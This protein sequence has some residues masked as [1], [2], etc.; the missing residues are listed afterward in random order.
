MLPVPC[1][2]DGR[3]HC[4]EKYR[5]ACVTQGEG[6]FCAN[7]RRY[8]LRPGSVLILAAGLRHRLHSTT[9]SPLRL[10]IIELLPGRAVAPGHEAL[11][12]DVFT[13]PPVVRCRGATGAETQRLLHRIRAEQQRCRA[14]SWLAVQAYL[15]QL[16]VL[17]YRRRTRLT[18]QRA[19][20]RGIDP[21]LRAAVRLMAERYAEPVRVRTLAECAHLSVRQFSARFKRTF[22]LTPMQ[23]LA[24]LRIAAAQELLRRSD[25]DVASIAR[26]V[27]Y[28]NVS[29]FYRTFAQYTGLSPGRFRHMEAEAAAAT[30]S[31]SRRAQPLMLLRA[32]HP[33]DCR[34]R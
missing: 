25:R 22:G 1:P 11:L 2:A 18:G 29:H 3:A 27:G 6:T 31:A 15:T 28:E 13:G 30:D 16:L 33:W 24:R 10:L 21:Q 17:L 9:S 8:P 14:A 32:S 20:A 7:G 23:Y 19:P 4:H 12:S 34:I 26:Q 5:I